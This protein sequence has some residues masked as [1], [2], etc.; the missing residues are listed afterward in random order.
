MK[1]H[2][3]YLIANYLTKLRNP[4]ISHILGTFKDNMLYDEQVI[5]TRGLKDRDSVRAGIILNLTKK[6]V[7]KNR[8]DPNRKNFENLYFENLFKYFLDGYPDY[9]RSTI[10]KMEPTYFDEISINK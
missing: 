10:L 1:N 3:L 7:V 4:R 5:M 8:F 2:D 6:V 9:V